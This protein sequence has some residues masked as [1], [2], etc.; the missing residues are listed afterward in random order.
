MRWVE[1][2]RIATAP[3]PRAPGRSPR[4]PRGPDRAAP[5]RLATSWPSTRARP[6][7]APSCSIGPAGR[8]LGAA[9]VP[10]DLSRTRPRRRTTLRRSGRA[11]SRPPR[12][13][14]PT[15]GAAP[16]DIAGDRADQPARDDDRLGSGDRPP[17][18]DAIVWQSRITAPFCDAL[19][20]ARPSSRSS[21]SGPGLPLDAYFS[22]PKIR[23]ILRLGAG[24]CA[25][26]PSAASSPSAPSTL[27]ALAPDRRPRPRHRRLERQ[28][29][30]AA[31]TSTAWPGTT[32][33]CGIV[34]VPRAVLPEVRPS[35]EVFGETDAA[36]LRPA[37]PDRRLR[38]RPAGRDV[39]P[40]LL[41]ARAGEEHLRHRRVPA[42]EHRDASRSSRPTAC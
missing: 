27:P 11:S 8:R 33:C 4:S 36:H 1:Q 9:G 25:S 7:R 40:G 28:P 17:V 39:R 14:S 18:A 10:A 6:R 12:R 37:D 23:H 42:H 15:P 22:G 2:S 13:S 38:R 3:C 34:G 26:A 41:R 21:A 35:S 24:R 29:D 5:C 30:A 31:S 20:A 16:A 32:S 19:R